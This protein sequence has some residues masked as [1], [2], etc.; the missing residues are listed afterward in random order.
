[1]LAWTKRSDQVSDEADLSIA[2]PSILYDGDVR[3]E[4][5]QRGAGEVVVVVMKVVDLLNAREPQQADLNHPP[6][7]HIRYQQHQVLHV[8]HCVP[9]TMSDSGRPS[10]R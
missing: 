1:V 7:A 9:R 4:P 2:R 3:V 6:Q 10:S 8:S 5:G